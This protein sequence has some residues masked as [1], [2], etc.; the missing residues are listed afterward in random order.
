M[1]VNGCQYNFECKSGS[2]VL[3]ARLSAFRVEFARPKIK[4]GRGSVNLA[5]IAKCGIIPIGAEFI[6]EAKV[7]SVEQVS[8][9]LTMRVG[10]N[11]NDSILQ[12]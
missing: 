3:K 6:C 10:W 4:R 12:I 9:P 8:R 5:Q 7:S 1:Q 11:I 2:Q